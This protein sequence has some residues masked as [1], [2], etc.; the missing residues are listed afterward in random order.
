MII[1]HKNISWV[2]NHPE[3]EVEFILSTLVPSFVKTLKINVLT[4]RIFAISY[5]PD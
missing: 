1:Q 3:N 2:K 5:E 4:N